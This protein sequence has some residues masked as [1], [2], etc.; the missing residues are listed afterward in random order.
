MATADHHALDQPNL[1][2]DDVDD[3]M[4]VDENEED[5]LDVRSIIVDDS[6]L[7]ALVT[8]PPDLRNVPENVGR[9]AAA[10]DHDDHDHNAENIH[11]DQQP[12]MKKQAASAMRVVVRIRPTTEP[13]QAFTIVPH[14]NNKKIRTQTK[15][16]EFSAILPPE[17]TQAQSYESIIRPYLPGLLLDEGQWAL[18]FC[19]GRTNSGKTHTVMGNFLHGNGGG[20]DDHDR[21]EW[22]FVPRVLHELL[23]DGTS[24]RSVGLACF[25]VYNDVIVDLLP[26][27][28]TS[29]TPIEE[30]LLNNVSEHHVTSTTQLQTLLGKCIKAR[31]TAD[32]QVNSHSS[33]SHAVMRIAIRPPNH[34]QN[35]KTP[36]YLWIVDLAGSEK[37]NNTKL[38]QETVKINTSLF[39]L[40]KCFL[41]LREGTAPPYRESKLTYILGKHWTS[42]HASRTT[43]LVNIGDNGRPE[44]DLYYAGVAAKA[45]IALPMNVE[46]KPKAHYDINGRVNKQYHQPLPQQHYQPTTTT[47]QLSQPIGYEQGQEKLLQ[48]VRALEDEIARMRN[49]QNV[50]A[51][52]QI[53]ILQ[54]ALNQLQADYQSQP[55]VSNIIESMKTEHQDVLTEKDNTIHALREQVQRLEERLVQLLQQ[56]QRP[57]SSSTTATTTPTNHRRRQDAAPMMSCQE[58]VEDQDNDD[59][60]NNG[61]EESEEEFAAAAESGSSFV[62][63]LSGHDEER[64]GENFVNDDDNNNNGQDESEKEPAA[65]AGSGSS[66]VADSV[67][68]TVLLAEDGVSSA[69]GIARQN[70]GKNSKGGKVS[71]LRQ[72]TM[73][74]VTD[75]CNAPFKAG[76]PLYDQLSTVYNDLPTLQTCRRIV[77]NKKNDPRTVLCVETVRPAILVQLAKENYDNVDALAKVMIR[78]YSGLVKADIECCFR[79]TNTKRK[80]A[81]A[82]KTPVPPQLHVPDGEDEAHPAPVGDTV[83]IVRFVKDQDGVERRCVISVDV[84]ASLSNE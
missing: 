79:N 53:T 9:I 4:V 46:Q 35:N 62:G 82:T 31:S 72:A 34:H 80:K 32:N 25:E 70:G 14:S 23:A 68:L 1:H 73:D 43:M 6:A 76:K 59:D 48:A 5:P 18:V 7:L 61:Q 33:R 21:T 19:Y 66:F 40:N 69:F 36:T 15:V 77:E 63:D 37:V 56:P 50:V 2:V 60:N 10:D 41:A 17:I 81:P 75:I 78:Q 65:A 22:G 20:S 71:L 26:E 11:P 13:I 83:E 47:E 57:V 39:V 8:H 52:T 38:L 16:Y 54:Q 28:G 29:A 30:L 55:H 51:E 24:Q 64:I 44:T 74:A 3:V 27:G 42:D 67:I 49:S 84:R 12:A 45:V 58:D